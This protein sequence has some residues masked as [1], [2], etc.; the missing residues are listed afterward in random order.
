[1]S[2]TSYQHYKIPG[3][4]AARPAAIKDLPPVSHSEDNGWDQLWWPCQECTKLHHVQLAHLSRVSH[5][6]LKAASRMA[7]T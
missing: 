5:K 2:S 3:K 7:D 4:P 6:A 1:M